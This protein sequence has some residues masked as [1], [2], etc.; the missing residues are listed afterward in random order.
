LV[1]QL[2][3]EKDNSMK[4]AVKNSFVLV[5]LSACACIGLAPSAK[6]DGAVYAMTN[7]LGN[8]QIVVYHRAGNGT[9]SL[10]QTIATTGGGSG[11]QLDATDSLGSQGSLAL[12]ST[13]RHLFAV[14]TETKVTL[15]TSTPTGD[16]QQG[17]ISSFL[18]ASDGTLTF[19]QKT[20]SGGLF[21]NSLTVNPFNNLLYVLNAGGPGINPVCGLSPNITGFT[22]SANGRMTAL[23]GSTRAINPGTS[24]GSGENCNP[25]G[26]PAIGFLCGQNPPAFPRSPAQV[27]FD[28]FGIA[29]VVTVKGTNSIY[30]FPVGLDGKPGSATVTQAPGPT[31]PT[32]FGFAFDFLDRLIVDEPFGASTTIPAQPASAISS[33]AIGLNGGLHPI[34]SNLANAEGLSCWIALVGQYA[35]ISDNGAG[36]TGGIGNVSTYKIGFDGSLTLL[37]ANAAEVNRPNDLAVG[38]EFFGFINYLYVLE[39]GTG[40][41]GVFQINFDGLLTSIETVSGLP[42]A[43]GAQGLA[44]Y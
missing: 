16:C 31:I 10:V 18:V 3:G 13:H 1:P 42:A 11:T 15:S 17:S 2:I 32:Y 7:A 43:A 14:N 5:A 37:S 24:P 39:S 23:A 27:G 19:V 4:I 21:P 20:P 26:F 12:D 8:N 33:F 35:Y 34:T 40:N 38:S 25:G 41:V 28:R 36:G 44:A 9:L 6:A 22:L 30:V 29:L